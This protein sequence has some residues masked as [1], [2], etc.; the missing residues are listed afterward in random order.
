MVKKTTKALARRVAKMETTLEKI[1][2]TFDQRQADHYTPV[3]GTNIPYLTAY[4]ENMSTLCPTVQSAGAAPNLPIEDGQIRLGDKITLLSLDIKGEVRAPP[5]SSATDVTNKVRLLLVRFKEDDNQTPAQLMSS[6]L[7]HYP[8]VAGTP[9]SYEATMY[10]PY[11]NVISQ[12]NSQDL[13]RYE[14]IYD[15][16]FYLQQLSSGSVPVSGQNSQNTYVHKFHIKKRW[17]KGLVIQYG[18]SLDTRPSLNSICLMAVSDS[19]L[20]GHPTI[21]YASRF[22]YMDA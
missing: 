16:L 13:I 7:Q 17:K 1:D 15:K 22:K 14:V 2:K 9:V 19:T 8:A 3:G 6:V 10:S 11:K 20:P 21:R 5:V 12:Y 18:K 4:A